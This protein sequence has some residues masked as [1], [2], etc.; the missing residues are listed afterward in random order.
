M[1]SQYFTSG[2]PFP[3]SLTSGKA[4]IMTGVSLVKSSIKIILAWPLFTR[5]FQD[6]F[7]SRIFDTIE[8]PNDDVLLD[9]CRGFIV[10]ALNKWE[11][12]IELLSVEIYRDSEISIKA[13]VVYKIR[14]VNLEDSINYTIYTN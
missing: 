3:L 13:E 2:L 1:A 10:E 7:G 5:I 8:E 9:L 14:E 4:D 11:R 6:G 12:R